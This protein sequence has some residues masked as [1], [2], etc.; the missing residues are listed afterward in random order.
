MSAAAQSP[1]KPAAVSPNATTRDWSGRQ[2]VQYPD[3]DIVALDNRFRRYIVGNTVMRRLHSGTFWAEGPAWNAGRPLLGVERYSQQRPDALDGGGCARLHIS[4]SFRVQQRQHVRLRGPGSFPAST[5]AAAWSATN[6]T[7]P[8]PPPRPLSRKASQFAQRH[9]SSPRRRHLAHLSSLWDQLAVTKALSRIRKAK[10]A[11]YRVDPKSGHMA[12]ITDEMDGPNGICFSPDY[13]KLY[14][15]DTGTGREI[16]VWDIDGKAVRNG[17]TIHPA[18]C[19]RQGASRAGRRH[20]L[21]RGRQYLGGS[22]SR[23]SGDNTQRR[24]YRNDPAAREL[25]QHQLLWH[26]AK[27]AVHV[28][29]PVALRRLRQYFGSGTSR[30]PAAVSL[31][32]PAPQWGGGRPSR[33]WPRNG[34]S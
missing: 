6:S 13:K 10:E 20:P 28:R 11:V 33:R 29:Q 25:R 5:A 19:P 14:V 24:A 2:P 12:M 7:E 4:Q 31:G 8:S 18:R 1:D 15:A 22:A 27:P 30:E 3:P 26:E 16:R 9:R 17:K 21:R 34:R 32:Q 23:R